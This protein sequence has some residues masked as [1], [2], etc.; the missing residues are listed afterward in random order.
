MN[1]ARVI[2][3]HRRAWTAPVGSAAHQLKWGSVLPIERPRRSWRCRVA[4]P[5]VALRA[6]LLRIL[7]A[8]PLPSVSQKGE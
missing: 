6:K 2:Y 3:T 5:A 7:S 1:S 8:S 4:A